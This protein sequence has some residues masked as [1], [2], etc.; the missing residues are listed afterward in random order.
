M[1]VFSYKY[2]AATH[3]ELFPKYQRFNWAMFNSEI[4]SMFCGQCLKWINHRAEGIWKNWGKSVSNFRH[5]IKVVK[6]GSVICEVTYWRSSSR[7]TDSFQVFLNH[8]SIR[9]WTAQLQDQ[10]VKQQTNKQKK[11]EVKIIWL[12]RNTRYSPRLHSHSLRED[13]HHIFVI[14]HHWCVFPL[15]YKKVCMVWEWVRG[16]C[17]CYKSVCEVSSL[18]DIQASTLSGVIAKWKCLWTTAT[19]PWS[20]RP[21]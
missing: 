2:C 13:R 16:N 20:V 5:R 19:Q 10:L 12:Q 8:L 18:L 11:N 3:Y 4:S 14:L 15:F 7:Y 1:Q 6:N 9:L 21:L 17:C